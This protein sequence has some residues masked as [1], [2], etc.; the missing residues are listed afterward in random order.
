MIRCSTM[1]R[2][3][4]P[5]PLALLGLLTPAPVAS[6]DLVVFEDFNDLQ[7]GNLSGQ[8]GWTSTSLGDS[9][10]SGQHSVVVT[11]P[12]T[13]ADRAF[14]SD[15]AVNVGS[16][17]AFAVSGQGVGD[18]GDT[19]GTLFF[20]FNL[21]GLT[22][23][24]S[25]G[26]TVA[27]EGFD[28]SNFR[29]Q[30]VFN[31]NADG[32]FIVRDDGANRGVTNVDLTL[33]TWYDLWLVMDNAGNSYSVYVGGGDLTGVTQVQ[34]GGKSSF[35]FRNDAGGE[36]TDFFVGTGGLGDSLF[37]DDL[38][39]G[40]GDESGSTPV[41]EPASAALLAVGLGLSCVRRRRLA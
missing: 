28:F 17:K 31:S 30:V 39:F 29:P 5:L 19:V 36:L 13:A 10:G 6:A 8:N 38:S 21:S 35:G 16:S 2:C 24:T 33:G 25:V 4:T 23:R 20:R 7:A 15:T 40:L 26:A 3:L 1:A 22:T 34:A 41:P 9:G 37:L 32:D 18:S 14:S 27:G 12:A 11:P